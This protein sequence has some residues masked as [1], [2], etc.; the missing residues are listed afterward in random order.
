[1]S[2]PI[3]NFHVRVPAKSP[4]T[5]YYDR[6]T[7]G[8][9]RGDGQLHTDHPP[10]VGDL[11]HLWDTDKKEGGTFRVLQRWW[12]YSSYGSFNWPLLQ[13]ESS[14]GPLLEVIVEPAEKPFHDQVSRPGTEDDEL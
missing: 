10:V 1:M 12:L 6:V 5:F 11:I 7:L 8:T 4:G 9:P 13:S 14:T 2:A 3:C